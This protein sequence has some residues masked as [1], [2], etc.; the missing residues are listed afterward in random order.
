MQG[1]EFTYLLRGQTF[2]IEPGTA[3]DEK[4]LCCF[5]GTG[6][7]VECF[8]DIST[9]CHAAV[10]FPDEQVLAGK[11]MSGRICKFPRSRAGI[12]HKSNAMGQQYL[13][14]GVH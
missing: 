2:R 14:F 6:Y 1:I 4:Q 8:M 9:P 11:G 3:A 7:A 10:F 12:R 13:H 5:V